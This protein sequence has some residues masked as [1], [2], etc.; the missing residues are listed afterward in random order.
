MGLPW[1]ILSTV[2]PSTPNQKTAGRYLPTASV[3]QTPFG[4]AMIN[5][6]LIVQIDSA[7]CAGCGACHQVCPSGIRHERGKRIERI[8]EGLAQGF[9]ME[10]KEMICAGYNI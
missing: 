7:K 2:C 4:H 8:L 10:S 1:T 5:R 6:S 3:P 9:Q